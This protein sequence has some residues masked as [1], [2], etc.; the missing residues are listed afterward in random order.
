VLVTRSRAPRPPGRPRSPQVDQAILAATLDEL[1]EV[2]YEAMS[3]E[4]IAARAGV[5]KTTIY[6][7]WPSKE[8]LVLAAIRGV[9]AEAPI[10]DTGNLRADLLT[11]VSTALALGTSSPLSQKLVF[12][13]ATSLA[14]QP[15]I[16]QGLLTQLLPARFQ[17]F[18]H[19]IER[20]K[21]R[22]ELRADLNTDVALGMIA[23]PIF[24][25]WLL[26]EIVASTPPPADLA[27][28]I[29]EAILYGMART[30]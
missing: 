22:G 26:G 15:D 1:A 8:A 17:D 6:R 30:R 11:M 29:V 3:I 10:S 13:A 9:Q 5:G 7:R 2:G 4:G 19:L 16:L 18:A 12:R 28:Q 24:Y 14:A 23:G 25:R 21:A 20:A 27:E